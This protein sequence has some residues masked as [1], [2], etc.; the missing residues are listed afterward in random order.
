MYL[1]DT[2]TVLYSSEQTPIV[3]TTT[4]TVCVEPTAF[5]QYDL[6]MLN[7]ASVVTSNSW[8]AF[9]G[10]YDN[11]VFK[12]SWVLGRIR[13]SFYTPIDH[14]MSWFWTTNYSPDWKTCNTNSWSLTNGNSIPSS[15]ESVLYFRRSFTGLSDMAAYESQFYYRDGIIAYLNGYEI[16]RDNMGNGPIL[17]SSKP[18]SSYASYSYHGVIRNGY[19]VSESECILS[20]E[21][22]LSQS[23]SIQFHSWLS[24]YASSHE[25]SSSSICYP[26]PVEEVR[27]SFDLDMMPVADFNSSSFISFS[28]ISSDLFLLYQV[29]SS[30]V[31]GWRLLTSPMLCPLTSFDIQGRLNMEDE[32]S[33]ANPSSSYT[34]IKVEYLTISL[35]RY[36]HHHYNMYKL[37]PREVMCFP[38]RM[39]ELYPMVCHQAYSVSRS[40]S[41]FDERYE[42]KM[43]D[44]VNIVVSNTDAV[45]CMADPSLP[46]GLS[47]NECSIV[48]SP[49]EAV[50]DL[51]MRIYWQDDYGTMSQNI[52]MNVMKSSSGSLFT[53]YLIIGVVIVVLVII[54][55]FGCRSKKS[56][57]PK[58]SNPS[59]EPK[60]PERVVPPP[61]PSVITDSSSHSG[62]M[63]L[64]GQGPVPTGIPM[65]VP[66][67]VPA[68]VPMNVPTGAPTGGSVGSPISV[69]IG[70]P[71]GVPVGSPTSVPMNVSTGIPYV[72]MKNPILTPVTT[73]MSAPIGSPTSA[74][75]RSPAS[76]PI[77][78]HFNPLIG[79]PNRIPQSIPK[80]NP[81]IIPLSAPINSRKNPYMNTPTIAPTNAPSSV[82]SQPPSSPNSTTASSYIPSKRSHQ[83]DQTMI[84]KNGNK[85]NLS[86]LSTKEILD[87]MRNND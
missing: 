81:Q 30:F 79:T 22:H 83:G 6:E 38:S 59:V 74:V 46:G 64:N 70:A 18:T 51:I 25:L 15:S 76:I 8:L 57:L 39:Y 29:P 36:N 67:G 44:T 56:K 72:P 9:Q 77:P 43:G 87:L 82:S 2:S 37:T 55:W 33:E 71:T 5:L 20:V 78:A 52:T 35:Q 45:G 4:G 69:P 75:A 31:N 49:T 58:K 62:N 17:P 21:I 73:P 50:T 26:L 41:L 34:Y 14:E 85:V 23:V 53:L 63:P 47:F 28:S 10:T 42:M 60:G 11:R 3:G 7:T 68:G 65:G 24:I 66:T 27:N 40:S 32:W 48:G 54:L 80:N 13:L 16:Y 86:S 84:D 1:P 12:S 19:D 61:V